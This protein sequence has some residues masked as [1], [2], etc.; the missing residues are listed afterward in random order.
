[1]LVRP[2]SAVKKSVVMRIGA[3]LAMMAILV[4]SNPASNGIFAHPHD[5]EQMHE[6]VVE[7]AE[8]IHYAENGTDAV[9]DFDSKDPEGSGIEW[10]VR[11][12]DAADFEISS[13]GVLTFM[14][15]PDYENP[16]DRGL[17]L[18]PGPETFDD[19]GE[20]AP[21]DNNYQITVSAT[22]MRAGPDAPLPAKRTDIDLTVIVGNADDTGELTLQWLQ[23]EVGTPIT[24]TLTDPDGVTSDPTWTWYTSKAADPVVGNLFH[25]TLVAGQTGTSYTPAAADEDRYLWVHVAYTDPHGAAKTADDKSK[26]PVRAAVSDNANASPDFEDNTDTRTVPESTAV[27]DPVG[28]P[29]TATDTDNDTLTY[30]L[31]AAADAV[32]ALDVE[33]FDINMATGQ[34]TVAQELDY[35]AAEGRTEEATAGEY[36]VMVRATD[37][38]GEVD[39]ITVTITAE[40]VNEDPIVTGRAEISVPEL[41]ADGVYV[42]L[43]DAPDVQPQNDGSRTY[44]EN[45]YVFEE[46]DHLDSIADW[47][48]EGD[49]AAAFDLSGGFEPRYIQFKEATDFENPTDANN[50]NV[51]EVTLV[52]IDTDPLKTGAAGIGRVNVW[53]IVTN[54]DEAGKVVFTA[55]ETAY[56]NEMLV[57]EVQDP[58]DKGGDLGEPYQGVHIV[59]WQWSRS[60]EDDDEANAPFVDIVGATTNRYTPLDDDRGYYLRAIATYT[61]PHSA[62]DD[63]DTPTDERIAGDSLKAG[64]AT[65]ANVVRLAPGPASVPTFDETGTVTRE[66]AENTLPGGDVG[67]PVA[68]MGPGTL[69]YSLEG[70]DAKYFDI[71]N[72]TDDKGQITVGGAEGKSSTDPELDFDDPMKKQR[73]SVTVKVEVM[74]GDASQNAQVDVNIIVTDV[75]E[76]PVITDADVDPSPMTMPTYPEINEDGAP[77]TAAVATFV[78]TDP[79]GDTI[80]WDLRG[81]DAALFTIDGGVL[82]FVNPPDYEDPKSRSGDDT[83][84]PEATGTPDETSGNTYSVVI[85]AIASRTSGDTGPAETVDTTVTVTVTDVDE[86]GEVVISW[87]Q[88]EVEDDEDDTNT[89]TNTGI[90]AT[91]TDPDGPPN[92]AL[93]VTDTKIVDAT[94]EWTVSEIVQGSL[95]VDND[96]HWGTA[97]GDGARL[98]E[99]TPVTSDENKYLRVTASYTDR[100]GDGKTE[101]MMSAYPVQA[102]GLGATNQSPDFEGEKVERSVAETAA[103]GAD[104]DDPVVAT[105]V[106]RSDTD[107]LTY[108]LR[109][110]IQADISSITGVTLPSG[111]GTGPSDDLAAFDIDKATGQITVA[112]K[113]DFESRGTPANGKYV[114][115]VTVTDPSGLGDI[116]VVVITARD[117]NEVPVLRGRPELTIREIDGG[118]ATAGS[119]LFVGNTVGAD[120]TVNVYNVDDEDDRASVKSWRLE[121]EDKAQFQLIGTVGRTL[122]FTTQPDY[123]NPA[124]ADGD[125]VYKVTVVAI[126]NGG[127]R[128]EFDVCIAVMNFDEAGK[129]TLRDEDGNELVQPHALGPITA[130]LTD[131]DGG[132]TGVTWQWERSQVNPPT[133]D[134]PL[135]DIAAE[136]GGTSA[137]YTPTNVDTSFFLKVTATYMDAKN[138]DPGDTDARMA[139]ATAAHAVL[140]VEDLKRNPEFSEET[141]TRTV[142]R[143]VAENAPSTTFVGEPLSLAMDLDDPQGVRLTYTLED[144]DNGSEDTAFFEL[145]MVDPT[146]GDPNNDDER[147]STQ[148]MVSLHDEAHDLDHEAEDRNGKYEVVLKVT[149]E[150]GLDDAITV[151]ITVTDRN[152][153]PSTPMEASDD[154]PTPPAN[155]APEFPSTETGM[156]SVPENTATDMP[157]GDPVAATDADAGDTLTYTLGGTDMAS[158]AINSGTGQIMVGA[159]SPDFEMPADADGNNAYEVTVTASDGNTAD[160]ATMSV[161][162]MVTDMGLADSYDANEDGM[163]DSTE[164]LNAVEDYFNDVSGIES[165]RIL[166]IVELYF[167]S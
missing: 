116:I 24:A 144:S 35:D 26:N 126:D 28:G 47:Q 161:T 57:A 55:G 114:V 90:T 46:P 128:G 100:N 109:A 142:T 162:I 85:R 107:I 66:V 37:P 88:P 152:E 13:A 27:G 138:E 31:V 29:I 157:I 150:S 34:I 67:G 119:P 45:E 160:D 11:G 23:P 56:L 15:S 82:Q 89:A 12:V 83:A 131:P 167:S 133:S 6:G 84:T 122:V 48:L 79:E 135:M 106:A 69:V 136:D 75:D 40:N 94:W 42:S 38:S 80:S 141:V 97:P 91:L 127:A 17:S 53:L 147:A 96:A 140:E 121:G 5:P 139:D 22:E 117:M 3:L 146:P 108:G 72:E 20:F 44:S 74:G 163:I 52:A 64:V 134:E 49:D 154:A 63:V 118:D 71:G 58:D 8:H 39:N 164:V 159:D 16:T 151:T 92:A 19:P 25:W 93:P 145:F 32:N 65:T 143:M 2:S 125:N 104:V 51:Y 77:N 50:D 62:A 155:N 111:D 166:D 113:L 70:S 95:D 110:V 59:T 43:P 153:A 149:D 14:E 132:V 61:D 41:T 120:P 148:I 137:T 21:T 102:A 124:D 60:L 98:A 112:Q 7:G 86:D 78:G 103:V 1:M 76:P 129:I 101:R 105:V 36:K 123:E 18:N 99:Y 30:E 73:F 54:V 10:N 115:V 9:R 4:L 130:E 156:R 68:A 165:E 87:L 158:F 33:F 81:A